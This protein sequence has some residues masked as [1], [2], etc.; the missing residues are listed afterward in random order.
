MKE[1]NKKEIAFERVI[2]F[3]DAVVAI[4]ITLLALELKID[5]PEDKHLSFSDLISP[6]HQYVAFLLSFVNIAGFWHTHHNF[7]THIKKIDEKLLS[8]NIVWLFL[9]VTLPFAT[10][11]LSTH[12]G[13]VAAIC[14]YSINI[15]L[16]SVIQNFIWDYADDKPDFLNTEYLDIKYQRDMRWMLNLDMING[17]IAIGVSFFM[18]KTAFLLL[19]FK[20]PILFFI[21]FLFKGRRKK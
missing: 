16:L 1:Y 4:A 11:V 5:I 2:F 6:W 8:L 15:F 14:L 18:P 19:F 9:I 7:F 17:L 10:S 21:P 12:F 20:I 3:S 13:D